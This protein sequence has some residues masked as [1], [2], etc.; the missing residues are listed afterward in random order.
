MRT[1]LI[2]PP[3]EEPL[4]L[5][6]AKQYL[7]VTHSL[8]DALITQQILSARRICE[9]ASRRSFITQTRSMTFA[10]PRADVERL[11]EGSGKI[12][13]PD[14]IYKG[15]QLIR[16]PVASV[17]SINRVRNDTG[18]SQVVDAGLFDVRADTNRI[19][20]RADFWEPCRDFDTLSI[21][22]VC[23]QPKA[24]FLASCPDLMEAMMIVLGNLYENRG[25]AT[26]QV[27]IEAQAILGRYWMPYTP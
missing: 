5:A 16:G 7:R 23:G 27:P 15:A 11:I 22:Y 18:E 21:V 1:K 20:W 2:T 6:V 9:E 24:Q 14:G 4:A 25:F 19:Q 8:E 13:D 26:Q 17:T 3:T 10:I 12:E